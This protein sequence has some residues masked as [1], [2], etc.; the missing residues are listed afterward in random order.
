MRLFDEKKYKL[1]NHDPK[2]QVETFIRYI[3]S[4]M[5]RF[6]R[7]TLLLCLVSHQYPQ[8]FKKLAK[9]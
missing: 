6:W 4:S 5:S 1:K 7:Q 3:C 8:K 9:N 2:A